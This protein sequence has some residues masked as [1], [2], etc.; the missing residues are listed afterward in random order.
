MEW[1]APGATEAQRS[2]CAEANIAGCV[3]MVAPPAARSSIKEWISKRS[4]SRPLPLAA[5]AGAGGPRRSDDRVPC[6]VCLPGRSP[7][8]G[9]E[10]DETENAIP[11]ACRCRWTARTRAIAAT[12]GGPAAS[13]DGAAA[14]R[15]TSIETSSMQS[16]AWSL[17]THCVGPGESRTLAHLAGASPRTSSTPILQICTRTARRAMGSRISSSAGPSNRSA[18]LAASSSTSSPGSSGGPL[19]AASSSCASA[20][21]SWYSSFHVMCPISAMEDAPPSMCSGAVVLAA[22]AATAAASGS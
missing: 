22:V 14:E 17:P 5:S 10:A 20:S 18:A 11:G 9:P 3:S 12:A 2:L 7:A 15:E 19:P 21:N 4:G 16:C 8:P 6:D 13:S 1:N